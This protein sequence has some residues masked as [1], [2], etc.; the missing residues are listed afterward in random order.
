VAVQP[1]AFMPLR[2]VGQAVGSL[3]AEFFYQFYDHTSKSYQSN[4]KFEI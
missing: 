1:R 2:D 4:L 3:E